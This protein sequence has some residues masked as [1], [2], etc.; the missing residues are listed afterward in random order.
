MRNCGRIFTT[1]KFGPERPGRKDNG[2][3]IPL[4]CYAFLLIGRLFYFKKPFK[5]DPVRLRRRK[6]YVKRKT[7]N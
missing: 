3:I 6:I 2:I 4:L 1:F 5:F 7:L